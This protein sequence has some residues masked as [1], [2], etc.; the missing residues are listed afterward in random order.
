[1]SRRSGAVH[2][3]YRATGGI[4]LRPASYRWRGAHQHGVGDGT[5]SGWR[6]PEQQNPNRVFLSVEA[7]HI[8]AVYLRETYELLGKTDSRLPATFCQMLLQAVSDWIL[9]YDESAAQSYF[10]YRMEDY[11]DAKASGEAE[12]GLEKP[13]T[14]EAAQGPRLD[15][16]FKPWSRRR[17]PA[18]ISS[19]RKGTKARRI[20]EATADLLA[21]S[22]KRKDAQPD[23]GVWE[24]CFPNGSYTIRF[25]SRASSVRRLTT[26]NRIG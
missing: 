21:L 9:C 24:E 23:W 25:M 19:I 26:T 3:S 14:L 22:R 20:L 16:R 11:E 4:R 8:S 7:T 18:V 17:L 10:E 5:P 6:E 15:K 13:Q 1:M 12:E 2:A